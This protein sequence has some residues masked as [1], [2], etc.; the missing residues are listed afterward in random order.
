MKIKNRFCAVRLSVRKRLFI[1]LF[2]QIFFISAVL[3]MLVNNNN[4]NNDNND[5]DNKMIPL[6]RPQNG[7]RLCYSFVL[8]ACL[9]MVLI[10]H[11]KNRKEKGGVP[12]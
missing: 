12:N 9:Q 3:D 7:G 4:N 1:Y 11:L 6:S 8:V 2:I 5:N 10:I